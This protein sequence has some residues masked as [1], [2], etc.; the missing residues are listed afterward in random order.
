MK[1][2]ECTPICI[3]VIALFMSMAALGHVHAAEPWYKARTF[4]N[5]VF[6][7]VEGETYGLEVTML[8][9]S[10]GVQILWRSGSGRL[11]RALLLDSTQ[12]GKNFVVE[13]PQ[14]IDGAGRWLL[15][16]SEKGMIAKGPRGQVFRLTRVPS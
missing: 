13:V 6:N 14:V 10:D 8:P 12:E 4:S 9:S 11:E 1:T 2:N 15:L 7:A 16:M 5:L 3:L